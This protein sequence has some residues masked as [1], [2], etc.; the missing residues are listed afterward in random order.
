MNEKLQY[1]SCVR[2]NLVMPPNTAMTSKEKHLRILMVVRQPKFPGGRQQRSLSI[3]K[4]R[5][6]DVWGWGES[7]MAAKD[8]FPSS[9][10]I[11]MVSREEI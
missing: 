9:V 7:A 3:V 6:A 11:A 8:V 1:M 2:W 10:A 4:T 5:M